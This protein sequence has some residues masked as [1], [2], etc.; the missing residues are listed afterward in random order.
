MT[1]R[2]SETVY[3]DGMGF[4]TTMSRQYA[5]PT[6]RATRGAFFLEFLNSAGPRPDQ[7]AVASGR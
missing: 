6:A 4:S 2:A 7:L 3:P 1:G 5:V